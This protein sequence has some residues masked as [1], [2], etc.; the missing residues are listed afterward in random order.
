MSVRFYNLLEL[1][2]YRKQCKAHLGRQIPRVSV[3][4]GTGCLANGSADVAEAGE[5]FRHFHDRVSRIL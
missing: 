4:G 5:G 1:R 2:E 3:C